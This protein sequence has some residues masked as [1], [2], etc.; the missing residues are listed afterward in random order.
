MYHSKTPQGIKDSV[1]SDL[2]SVHGNIR[3]VIATSAP[4]MGVNIPK[5]KKVIIFVCPRK[6]RDISASCWKS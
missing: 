3:L 2:L 5:V 4:G 1:L 6:Y